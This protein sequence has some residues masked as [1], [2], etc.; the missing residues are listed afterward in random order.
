[1]DE[2]ELT[3]DGGETIVGPVTLD[4]IRRGLLARRIP[5]DA[6]ARRVG[7]DNWVGVRI[8]AGANEE[9]RE[10]PAL[11]AKKPGSPRPLLAILGIVGGVVFARYA[12]FDT[13][14]VVGWEMF[15]RSLDRGE[16]T[17]L[18]LVMNSAALWKCFGLALVGGL[19]GWTAG[20]PGKKTSNAPNE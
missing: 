14:D 7:E 6:R 8:L 15:W 4:Q 2:Y 10:E 3:S 1:M 12:M 18:R 17:S 11:D 16:P 9:E 13:L 20:T 19:I 5:A